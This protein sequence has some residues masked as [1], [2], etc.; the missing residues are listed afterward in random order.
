MKYN[1]YKKGNRLFSHKGTW[2]NLKYLLEVK[3]ASLKC[4]IL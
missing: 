2:I 4:Y 3:E 1:L